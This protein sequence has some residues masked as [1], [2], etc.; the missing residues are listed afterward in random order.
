MSDCPKK[1]RV[2]IERAWI[3]EK[4]YPH[5]AQYV[6]EQIIRGGLEGVISQIAGP[7]REG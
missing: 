6:A 5:Y 1:M 3:T 7:D 4:E 2:E